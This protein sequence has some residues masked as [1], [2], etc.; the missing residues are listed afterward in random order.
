MF[1]FA[2]RIASFYSFQCTVTTKW[3]TASLLSSVIHFTL[4]ASVKVVCL[5]FSLESNI[6]CGTEITWGR[7]NWSSTEAA[8]KKM[9]QT[10]FSF[11]RWWH[12]V[13]MGWAHLAAVQMD[14]S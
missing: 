4:I 3:L 2:T 13:L 6:T 14:I 10:N 1:R 5:S 12:V 7:N 9:E 8:V 11:S